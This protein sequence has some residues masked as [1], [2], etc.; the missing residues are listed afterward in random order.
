MFH[1]F[2]CD[3][4]TEQPPFFIICKNTNMKQKKNSYTLGLI[5]NDVNDE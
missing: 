2:F 3:F 5:L 1:L 4:G